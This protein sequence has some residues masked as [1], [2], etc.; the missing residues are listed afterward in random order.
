MVKK[1]N[2][3]ENISHFFNLMKLIPNKQQWKRWSFPTKLGVIAAYL[4]ILSIIYFIIIFFYNLGP[5]IIQKIGHYKYTKSVANGLLLYSKGELGRA[6]RK[7]DNVVKYAPKSDIKD[8]YFWLSE[9]YCRNNKYEKCFQALKY[10]FS[11]IE[12][13]PSIFDLEYLATVRFATLINSGKFKELYNDTLNIINIGGLSHLKEIELIANLV[14]DKENEAEKL[15]KKKKYEFETEP[16]YRNL[17]YALWSHAAAHF[18]KNNDQLKYL[19]SLVFLRH[20]NPENFDIDFFCDY[21]SLTNLTLNSISSRIKYQKNID[22]NILK[23]KN[24]YLFNLYKSEIVKFAMSVGSLSGLKMYFEDTP[25]VNVSK[26]ET[27]IT[28]YLSKETT[29]SYNPV[30]I[31]D[32]IA[33]LWISG[34][35]HKLVDSLY[36]NEIFV[37]IIKIDNLT[38]KVVEIEKIDGFNVFWIDSYYTGNNNFL[39]LTSS[40]TGHFLDISAILVKEN[41]IVPYNEQKYNYHSHD[42]FV[43]ISGNKATIMWKFEILNLCDKFEPNVARKVFGVKEIEYL[44]NGKFEFARKSYPNPALEFFENLSRTKMKL[45]DYLTDS[46]YIENM[47]IKDDKFKKFLNKGIL[48]CYQRTLIDDT[49]LYQHPMMYPS[50]SALRVSYPDEQVDYFILVKRIKNEIK[51]LDIFEVKETKVIKSVF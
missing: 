49:F 45:Q 17:Q 50:I 51:V 29:I 34:N 28:K 35:S 31:N 6:S 36:L 5:Y 15:L 22:N 24:S 27:L 32:K 16:F 9:S 8:L 18:Y 21:V 3:I 12:K 30:K 39:L 1:N 10:Y 26:L 47:E 2:L 23:F 20:S 25:C 19:L 43:F 37:R 14:N 7:L 13:N 11:H 46:M 48:P 40:G 44:S 38:M 4:T 41:K 33:I 42:P